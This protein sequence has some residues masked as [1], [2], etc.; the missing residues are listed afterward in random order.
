MLLLSRAQASIRIKRALIIQKTQQNYN[1]IHRKAAAKYEISSAKQ[2]KKNQMFQADYKLIF[3]RKT[4]S[5]M[6]RQ[7]TLTARLRLWTD[8][9]TQS[10]NN[11]KSKTHLGFLFC[12]WKRGCKDFKISWGFFFIRSLIFCSILGL[13]IKLLL[14]KY[15]TAIWILPT[16][17]LKPFKCSDI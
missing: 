1:S 16:R 9:D 5:R 14:E 13:R 11:S 4:E 2:K 10:R 8:N 6:S 17:A 15:S 7:F 12:G 3:N